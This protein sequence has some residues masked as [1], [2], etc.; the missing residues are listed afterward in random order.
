VNPDSVMRVARPTDRLA[1]ISD[2]YEKGLGVRV[3]A[4]AGELDLLVPDARQLLEHLLEARRQLGRVRVAAD[5]VANGVQDDAPLP[6]RDEDAVAA[7]GGLG[8]TGRL[9]E[10]LG[11]A[12]ADRRGVSCGPLFNASTR[13]YRGTL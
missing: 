6:G 1:A 3:L 8:G 13:R 2:M 4:V 10:G 9:G 7:G 11:G 12:P 5:R